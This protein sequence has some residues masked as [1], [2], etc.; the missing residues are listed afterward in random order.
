M[1]VKVFGK[2][3]CAKCQTT[4]NK[5]NH[6][7]RKNGLADSVALEFHDMDTI[8]GMAEGAYHDVL[9]IPTTILEREGAVLARW[10]GEVPATEQFRGYFETVPAGV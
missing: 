6:F 10:D 5:F 9:K 7:I 1:K 8:E 4:E 2:Q 3:G